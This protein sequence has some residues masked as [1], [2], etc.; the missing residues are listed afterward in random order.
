M[1][2]SLPQSGRRG[3]RLRALAVAL[4]LAA[5]LAL[6]FAATAGADAFTPESGPSENA[7]SIDTLYKI[8][9]FMGLVVIGLVWTLLFFS[10]VR[11][12]A[13]RGAIAPQ[14]RGNTRLEL[15]WTLGATAIVVVIAVITFLFLDDIKNPE[16]SGPSGLAQARSENA[17]LNQPPPPEGRELKIEVS[18][19]QY[20]WRYR[21]PN[22]A[23]SFHDLVVPRDTTVTLNITSNDVAH[24]WWIPK[25]GGKADSIRGLTNETWFKATE[26]GTFPG[27]C[28]EF[29]GDNHAAMTAKVVVVEPAEYERWVDEQVKLIQQAR[30]AVA[31]QRAQSQAPGG[32]ATQAGAG[33]GT[34]TPRGTES[35]RPG[36][37]PLASDERGN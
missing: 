27:Q 24:S 26:T 9:F 11:F 1:R 34:G 16:S 31:K 30:D 19:Q 32:S 15:G 22:G 5:A 17:V 37:G 35:Q 13:R 3:R 20:F 6:V 29:C 10:L 21:Y 36:Q 14:V 33:G 12:R 28:A 25:L 8:L 7:N 4:V 18:G 2:R 23:V